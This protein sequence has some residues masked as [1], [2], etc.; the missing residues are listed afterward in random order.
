MG[1]DKKVIVNDVVLKKY[2]ITATPSTQFMYFPKTGQ[3]LNL[4]AITVAQADELVK[5]GDK[6]FKPK[7]KEEKAKN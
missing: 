3:T 7:A 2:D 5:R 1:E 4:R 6:F